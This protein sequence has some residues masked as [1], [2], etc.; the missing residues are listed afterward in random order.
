M[1]LNKLENT[2]IMSFGHKNKRVNVWKLLLIIRYIKYYVR[3]N[4]I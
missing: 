1:W 4:R 3:G 2:V